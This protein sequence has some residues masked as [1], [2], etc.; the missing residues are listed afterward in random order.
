M[1]AND[2]VMAFIRHWNAGEIEAGQRYLAPD[3]VRRG[4]ESDWA[5]IPRDQ[6]LLWWSGYSRAFPDAH[7]EI[8]DVAAGADTVAVR[9]R[10]TGTFTA[11]WELGQR[12]I[13]PNHKGYEVFGVLFFKVRDG[14]IRS[15]D[16][17]GYGSTEKSL[18]NVCGD[19]FSD[20]SATL[21]DAV[22]ASQNRAPLS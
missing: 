22:R 2:V 14:F 6:Y 19:I 17:L 12:V 7:W 21:P 8:L 18:T 4:A 13:A 16:Y 3:F 5:A 1:S 10:E 11:P 9:L 15:Y 20:P